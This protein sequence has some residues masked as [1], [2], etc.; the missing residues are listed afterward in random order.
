M[1]FPESWLRE[2][3][4]PALS[5]EQLADTLTMAGMEVEEF[6][7]VAPPFSHVVVGEVL[8]TQKHPDADRLN[9]C[10][11]K[12]DA[13][14]VL[15]VV[16]GA[17]N[18][19]AGIKVP[20]ALVGAQL[21]PV[22][23]GGEPFL[24]KL[25]KLRGVESQGML[26]SAKELKISDDADGLLVL[27]DDALVGSS[28][29]GHLKLDDTL[30]TLKLT[31]NL[32][33]CLSVYGIARELAAL[34]GAPLMAPKVA[35]V[36]PGH[37]ARLPVRVHAPDLCGRFSGRIIRNINAK[38][39]TPGWMVDRLA[40]C[41][42]R[43]ISPLVDISNYVM[44]ELGRPSHVFDLDKIQGDLTVRWAKAGESLTLLNDQTVQLDEAVGVI[45]DDVA[46]EALAGIMGGKSTA[47]SNATQNIFVESAFWWPQA[48]AGRARKFQFSSEASHRFER[49]VDTQ[50]TV[51]HLE[52]IT[53][54]IQQ[55]CGGEAGV[56]DDQII[57]LPISKPIEL[58]VARVEKVVGMPI[59]QAQCKDVFLRLGLGVNEAPGVLGVTP[60]SWR[61]D[62]QIEEDLIEEVIRIL[63]FHTLPDTP[64]VAAITPRVRFESERGLSS[65]RHSVA[66]LDYQETINFSFVQERWERDF[67]NN[68][69]PIRLL[70]PIAAPLSVMRSSLLGGLVAILQFN[71]AHKTSRV[72]IFEVGRIF[73]KDANAIASHQVVGG[74]AQPTRLGGLAYGNVNSL[75]WDVRDRNVDF[76]DVKGDVEAL[77][78]SQV[79]RFLPAD[80]PALHPGRS[81][82]VEVNGVVV[83]HVGELHPRWRQAYDLPLAPIL[84]ELDAAA[85]MHRP[86][87]KATPVQRMQSVWRDIAVV[88]Q[89]HIKHDALIKTILLAEPSLVRSARLFDVYK[90]NGVSAS[91]LLVGESSLAVRI[92]LFD[93]NSP[94]ND[95][96]VDVVIKNVLQAL[97]LEL[98]V[99]LRV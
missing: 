1:Q 23:E 93:E 84:F 4:N 31:P 32:G 73:Q 34:T 6:K 88:A 40:R 44:F 77:F 57:N 45:A 72:R 66:A 91:D 22:K 38:A 47:V 92:E 41:G 87:P 18:V 71:L 39:V 78:A 8:S 79:L 86:L 14:T 11:V 96:R 46:V 35:D 2:F 13:N 17:A 69:D 15:T 81:A 7:S 67:A 30:F 27:S 56:V 94:L 90:P 65:V 97:T 54:L 74:V 3:C 98:G 76:F 21:P 36:V 26:C 50:N 28:I 80:H 49:G 70:N 63:G 12:V 64:P 29:R 68:V 95:E 16:C 42:Q 55:I 43:S 48:I 83:G 51:A 19:R 99:R 82:Q 25:G 59:T 37:T 33:H 61:F 53:E 62:L 52:R 58:R 24:I 5:T 60:P 20:C 89:D 10:Q 85:L 9:V 75:H